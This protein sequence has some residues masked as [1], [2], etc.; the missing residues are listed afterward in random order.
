[1]EVISSTPEMKAWSAARLR[2]CRTIGFA[3]TMGYL[4]DGHVSL[5]RKARAENDAVVASIFV[6]PTQFGP[7]EDL[8]T[9]PRDPESDLSKCKE[10]AVDAVFMPNPTQIYGPDHQTFVEVTE[11]SK[12]LCGASRPGHFRGVATVVLKLFNIVKP[13]SA[14][15]GMKDYQQLRVITTMVRD[16]DLEVNIVPCP[17]V[18]EPDGLA[19]SSRNS[20]LSPEERKRAL[21]LH[22]ALMAAKALFEFG[23][24]TAAKYLEAMEARIK[25]TPGANP[26]YI[27]LTDPRTLEEL[28]TVHD[29]ALAVLAVRI[30]K[31]RLIDNMVFERS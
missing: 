4:H 20:Y 5:L 27:K 9:Y 22:E 24:K 7:N 1:M 12:P 25:A 11:V 19:M 3:P 28:E 17:T 21:C 13:T 10:A 26:D 16:L 2:D 30:G 23:E 14:Y 15:F 31:T 8:S 18:R 29:G 6:N